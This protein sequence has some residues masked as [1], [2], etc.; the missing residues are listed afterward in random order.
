MS[1]HLSDTRPFRFKQFSLNHHQST[2]KVGI[3][4]TLL[5]IWADISGVTR[6]LDVGTGSGVIALL[7][8]G[9][10]SLSVDAIDIDDKSID[11]A[12]ANFSS[13]PYSELLT[14]YHLSLQEYSHQHEN[15]YDLI[16]SNPPFFTDGF[17]VA[18]TRI[19]NARHTKTLSHFE[20][21]K[22]VRQLLNLGGRFCVVIPYA[23]SKEFTAAAQKNGLFPIRQ[24][25]VFPRRG[26]SP[27]RIYLE[28]SHEQSFGLKT[29]MLSIREENG[30]YSREFRQI[31]SEYYLI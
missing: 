11:E 25:L 27:N 14:A 2:M 15:K 30:N 29:E 6:V 31:V 12:R 23:V 21:T 22:G 7:I 24:M 8:A 17:P 9:R 13:S 10:A 4:A 28:F 5:G 1:K 20:L 18:D 3:D 16:V 26:L 19:N